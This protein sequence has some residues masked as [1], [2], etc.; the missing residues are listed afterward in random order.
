VERGLLLPLVRTQSALQELRAIPVDL[1]LVTE[2]LGKGVLEL[3]SIPNQMARP[4][5]APPG[6][7][8]ELVRL[9]RQAFRSLAD[10][11]T[12][13]EEARRLR[14][15]IAYV[16]GEE[17]ARLIDKVLNSSAAIVRVLK[18]FYRFGE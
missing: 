12:F 4:F 11:S 1:S 16:P 15:D 17:A 13:R 8:P 9:Y 5:V 3:L 7:P 14:F 2:P 6:T 10:D 18:S